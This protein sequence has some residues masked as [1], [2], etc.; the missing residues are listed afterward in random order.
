[1]SYSHNQRK[2]MRRRLKDIPSGFYVDSEGVIS[3]RTSSWNRVNRVYQKN[4]RIIDE[5]G[6]TDRTPFL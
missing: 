4:H 6:L 1:M 3:S 2:K 5:M